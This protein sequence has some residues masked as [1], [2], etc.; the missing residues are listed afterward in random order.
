M[1]TQGLISLQFLNTL[2]ET[3]ALQ[4]LLNCFPVAEY[5]HR[6]G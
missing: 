1:I 3:A 4:V 5:F 2:L 6:T